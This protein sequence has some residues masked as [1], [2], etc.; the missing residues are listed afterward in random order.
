MVS[1]QTP[2]AELLADSRCGVGFQLIS[3]LVG[4]SGISFVG[5]LPASVQKTTVFAAGI[6]TNA[7]HA[8]A[9]T[10]LLRFI[11]SPDH[12]ALLRS[13]GLAASDRRSLK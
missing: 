11:A 5:P 2:I 8:A 1:A 12:D 9:G 13:F 10:A 6:P 3:E 4:A 7:A